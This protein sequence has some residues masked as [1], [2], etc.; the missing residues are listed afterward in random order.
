MERR[1]EMPRDRRTESKA[2]EVPAR[3]SVKEP[4]GPPTTRTRA[5]GYQVVYA[6]RAQVTTGYYD[7]RLH[8]CDVLS[9]DN[10]GILLEEKVSVVVSPEHARDL[11]R[12]LG[13]SLAQYEERFGSLRSKP[14]ETTADTES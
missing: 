7:V 11:H 6:N 1:R 14:A 3:K 5:A 8:F 10:K 4:D 9:A 13:L 2:P 12:V